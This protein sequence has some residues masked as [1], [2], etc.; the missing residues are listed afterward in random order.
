MTPSTARA[1]PWRSARNLAKIA[2]LVA[3]DR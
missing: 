3:E 1:V 2:P